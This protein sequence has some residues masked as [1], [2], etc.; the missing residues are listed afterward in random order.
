MLPLCITVELFCWPVRNIFHEFICMALYVIWP[1]RN[2]HILDY[3]NF[4]VAPAKILDSNMLLKWSTI[5]LLVSHSRWVQPKKTSS[6]NDVGSSKSTSFM[7]IFHV[8]LMSCFFFQPAWCR[9]N[10]QVRI[11][12]FSR[13][14]DKHSQF[15]TFPNR[16]PREL[17]QTVSQQSCHRMTEQ[18]S[19]KRN[20][21]IFHTGPWF[22]PLVFW[23]TFPNIWA[24]SNFGIFN[25]FGHLP[26]LPGYKLILRLLL[27]L[28]NLVVLL[29][30]LLF[31]LLPFPAQ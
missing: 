30:Y 26:L 13:L 19:L 5:S 25:H 7:S 11:V 29:Q 10:T 15:G 21:W 27:D 16:I 9:P 31:L 3:C 23:Y 18:I 24:F 12:L 14:T 17:P 6:R 4:S 22:R 8:G 28:R 2:T 20:D 1:R